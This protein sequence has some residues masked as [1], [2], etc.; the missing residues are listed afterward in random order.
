M[1]YGDLTTDHNDVVGDN[2]A[3]SMGPGDRHYHPNSMRTHS[4]RIQRLGKR[5]PQ[6]GVLLEP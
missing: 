5:L 3:L 6:N 2:L 4:G 1:S